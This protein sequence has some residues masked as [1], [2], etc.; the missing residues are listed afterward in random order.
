MSEKTSAEGSAHNTNLC[1]VHTKWGRHQAQII[2]ETIQDEG[3]Y[4]LVKMI[5]SSFT[6][7][8]QVKVFTIDCIEYI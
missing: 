6:A 1:W 5:N 2:M 4:V 8:E 7:D 3:H